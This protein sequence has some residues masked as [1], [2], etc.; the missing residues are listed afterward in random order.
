MAVITIVACLP[1]FYGVEQRML[2]VK[3]R[4][5]A[6]KEVL[7]LT[8]GKMVPIEVARARHHGTVSAEAVEG[9]TVTDGS[10]GTG[11]SG[12]PPVE[13]SAVDEPPGEGT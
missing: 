3:L 5:A 13:R 8:T 7:D 1:I 10:V 4:F 2:R 11:A 6:E 12:T 9:D